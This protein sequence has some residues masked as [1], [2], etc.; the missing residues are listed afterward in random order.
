MNILITL[1][2]IALVAYGMLKQYNPQVVLMTAGI[3]FFVT[4]YYYLG[5]SPIPL[6]KSNGFLVFDIWEKF[7]D[8]TNNRLASIGLTL[9]SIA[10]VST[11]LNKI[12]AS[13]SL[14]KATSNVILKISNPYILL[15]VA[16]IVVSILYIFI[17]GATSL[18][19]LLMATIYPILR[20]AGISAKTMAATIIIPTS[21][22]YGPGQ[23]NAVV[24]AEA[25]NLNMIDYVILHQT[26]LQ[27][28]M[29]LAIAIINVVYQRYMDKKE[30]FNYLEEKGQFLNTLEENKAEKEESPKYYALFP[31]IPFVLLILFSGMFI[32]EFT[33]S[34]P[35]AMM[36]TI[37][38]CM[39]IEM[40]RFRSIKKAFSHFQAWLEGTGAIFATVIT[41]MIAAEFFAKGLESVGAISSLLTA[42]EQF[43]LPPVLLAILFC[44]FILLTAFIT[45]SG[46][47][48]VLAFVSLVPSVSAQF[49][50][51]PLLMLVPILT[52]A[53]VG[54][55]MSPVAGVVITV[56]GMAKLSPFDII[57]RTSVP[58]I[59][60]LI[61]TLVYSFIRYS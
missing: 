36:S 59:T 47:A 57:K 50:I 54:R 37:M 41:L 26:P 15:F 7:S 22:E 3:V 25:I 6:E 33:I 24:G 61:I 10:G 28:I 20:N 49:G 21:W 27:V 12:G 52:A 16:L 32:E 55:S 13:S 43:A 4:S 2:V 17:T 40:I 23:I 48:P 8:I 46:N 60:S 45:G 5:L 51:N 1:L 44:L 53:G 38:I 42:A 18:S 35:V 34:I 31:L 11:Y 29:V 9:V 56:S 39:I 14:I 58:V 30:N 19:L